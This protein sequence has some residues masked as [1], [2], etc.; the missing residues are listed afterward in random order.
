MI[1]E[2]I[3]KKALDASYEAAK[4]SLR[5]SGSK[6]TASSEEIEESIDLHI[7]SVKNWAEEI[8]FSDL[9][10][11]KRTTDVF[12]HL[13]LLVYPK[14]LR[15][16]RVEN[17][18][19]IP[20]DK[21]FDDAHHIVLLGQPGA[22]KT[23]SMKFLCQSLLYDDKF[24]KDRFSFPI[25]IKFRDLNGLR[26]PRDST[27]LFSAIYNI[28]G[29]NITFPSNLA[30][31]NES[32]SQRRA[33][34]EKLIF[35]MLDEMQVLLILDGFDELAKTKNT[36]GAITD[37]TKLVM[38]LEQA[39]VVLTS[40]TGDFAYN[41]EK[42]KQYE[43]ASLTQPQILIFA[44]KWLKTSRTANAFLKKIQSSPFWDTAIRPLTLAH[45][46]AIYERAGTIPDKPKSVYNKIV[47]LLLEEWD[48]QRS[49]RRPS[50]YAEFD[51][52]RK[53]EFLCNLAHSLTTALQSSVFSERDLIESYNAIH[54]DFA[55][56]P[57]EARQVV[58]ELETHT[59]L[60]IQ[61]GYEEYEFA[62]KSLQEYLTAEYLVRLPSI[63]KALELYKIP[64]EL[65]IAVT[66]SSKPS[67][68]FSE[69]VFYRFLN[70][71]VPVQFLQ[72]FITR[73][74]LEKPDFNMDIRVGLSLITLFSL[75]IESR[76]SSPQHPELTNLDIYVISKF[77]NLMSLVLARN[78]LDL[79]NRYYE[80]V[81]T[82]VLPTDSGYGKTTRLSKRKGID[83]EGL[84][85]LPKFLYVSD[86]FYSSLYENP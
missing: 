55:L 74:N 41:I 83:I 7:K 85:N 72:P 68:Y 26:V 63:P 20:L 61:S 2:Y 40:R 75:Y 12:V 22:G 32:T 76:I 82:H 43:L 28:L 8:S 60:F 77:D 86:S 13:D 46:C 19:L 52:G 23:T 56:V 59:G 18:E 21:M 45:L 11:P 39:A 44:K 48:E 15:L 9:K 27:I 31:D 58:S 37:V 42:A 47:R 16:S 6:L 33:I 4:K 78:T 62:H 14:R 57:G 64:N 17:I 70:K 69:L 66:I 54:K 3:I 79:I 25:F 80:K 30:N 71:G 1:K 36:Q 65:A 34:K 49:V 5:E 51:V 84:P 35:R 67:Q 50:R 29:L 73:L 10:K 81:S 38:H 53:F 24:C